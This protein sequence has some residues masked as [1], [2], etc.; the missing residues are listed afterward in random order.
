MCFF[1]IC[2]WIFGCTCAFDYYLCRLMDFNS[3][4]IKRSFIFFFFFT[5][6]GRPVAI[7]FS[8]KILFPIERISIRK[9]KRFEQEVDK[10]PIF[11]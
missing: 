10:K 4:V 7:D 3:W 1:G 11:H 8:A 5:I 9:F 2:I 6:S